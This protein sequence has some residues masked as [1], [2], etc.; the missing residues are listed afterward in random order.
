MITAPH[1]RQMIEAKPFRPFRIFMSDGSHHDVPHS[2]FAWVF[3]SIV[4]V[5]SRTRLEGGWRL[6][7]RVILA[8]RLA[9]GASPRA[10]S[11]TRQAK[12]LRFHRNTCSVARTSSGRGQP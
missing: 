12:A 7:Q 4:F 3:G 8:A 11:Q 10:E 5:R 2:E 1:I 9:L 6:R